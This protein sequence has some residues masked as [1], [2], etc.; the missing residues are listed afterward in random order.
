M[1]D[2]GI[3]WK[4]VF[5]WVILLVFLACIVFYFFDWMNF[6]AMIGSFTSKIDLP[7]IGALNL[8]GI[9]DF[10]TK[11]AALIGI[12]VPLGITALSYYIKNY[13]TNKLLDQKIAEISTTKLSLTQQASSK[14]QELQHQIDLLNGDTTADTLQ[15]NLSKITSEKQILSNQVEQLRGQVIQLSSQ[16]KDIINQLWQASGGKVT[17]IAGE[18]VK[19]IELEPKIIVK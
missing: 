12:A 4:G 1:V 17:E 10:L 6:R 11:N 7:K 13:Q 19:I 3:N 16:P 9:T 5:F 18:T 8:S 2:T 15:T 14:E